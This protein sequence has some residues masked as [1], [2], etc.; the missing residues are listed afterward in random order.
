MDPQDSP[1]LL[2]PAPAPRRARPTRRSATMLVLVAA[3]AVLTI[4]AGLLP[5]PYVVLGPGPT[6]NTLGTLSGGAP[7][8]KI[9]GRQTYPTT[10][11][12]N[13]VTVSVT[14]GP[15]YHLDLLTALRGWVD[16]KVAVVPEDVVFPPN[17]SVTQ[18]EQQNTQEMTGS[19][20]DATYVA[21]H[22]L[23]IP[24]GEQ[25]VVQSLVSGSPADGHLK[26]GDVIRTVDGKTVGSPDAVRSIIEAHK[27]GDTITMTVDRAGKTLT[28]QVV[29]AEQSGRTVVGFYPATQFS[30]PFTVSIDPGNIGGPS[31]GLMFTLGIIDK[32]TPE[33]LTGGKFIA[34]TGTIDSA[35]TV[36]PIGGIQ[37]KM[38]AARAAGAT[39][40]LTPAG[41]CAEALASDPAGLKLVKVSSLDTAL[42][43]LSDIRSGAATPSCTG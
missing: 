35:G 15:G 14:G 38:V 5:V 13:L 6:E 2:E 3:V 34:G 31:A 16:S 8:I 20:Q 19:Q 42:S 40:F 37:Q 41:N 10:G 32:L 28:V 25:V 43:A 12:L 1:T 29:A 4:V 18:V 33:N 30:F 17:T 26:P 27:P 24:V 23:G 22:H 36:G 39:F 21:L 9:T 7:L 11:H